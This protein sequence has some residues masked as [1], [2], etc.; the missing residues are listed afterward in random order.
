MSKKLRLLLIGFG[1]AAQAFVKMLSEKE[2]YLAEEKDIQV[3]VT[4]IAGN[5]KGS[6][7]D[8]NGIDLCAILE[9]QQ[10]NS[11]FENA[12]S[13]NTLEVIAQAEADVAI[14]LSPLS[15]MDGQPAISHIKAAFDRG[16]HV[17]TANKGPI[18]WA[19]EDLCS[20]AENRAVKFL[21]ETTVMD[22]APVFNLMHHCLKGCEILSFEGILN[23]TTNFILE[24]MEQ[25]GHFA[26]AVA[27]AQRRGFA[28]ADPEMDITGMDAAA[29]TC[30][31][32]NALM[33]AR[34][35]PPE[36][37]TRGIEDITQSQVAQALA[38]GQKIKL[39]CRGLRDGSSVCGEVSPVWLPLAHPF[40][41]ISGTS[42]VLTIETDLMGK[43]T[44]IEHDPEIRQT[45]YG[46][47][48]DMLQLIR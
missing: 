1:N 46:I 37:A 5:R 14:E 43:L 11:K 16:M 29:K 30:A 25:G 13:F 3:L 24:E 40:A 38:T 47:F 10:I 12:L 36:V 34:L 18:A 45:A 48:S 22:G 8:K 31:L 32:A 15:I 2:R 33:F 21:Y 27:A 6:L 20:L 23:T 41:G 35:T 28:E 17:I 4:A 7:L 42:S 26:D 39:L 9:R 19:F 44:V